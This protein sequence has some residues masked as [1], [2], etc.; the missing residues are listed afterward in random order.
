MRFVLYLG[1]GV[2]APHPWPLPV[3]QFLNCQDYEAGYCA[4]QNISCNLVS[5]LRR[6]FTPSALFLLLC[7]VNHPLSDYHYILV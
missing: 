6:R 2:Q 4:R 5:G 7:H 1:C 3:K